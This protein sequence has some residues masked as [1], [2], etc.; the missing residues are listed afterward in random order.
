MEIITW[1]YSSGT[2]WLFSCPIAKYD[3]YIILQIISLDVSPAKRPDTVLMS[4]SYT[5]DKTPD[6]DA[7]VE[8]Y[9][10]EMQAPSNC[11]SLCEGR[12]HRQPACISITEGLKVA[13]QFCDKSSM[14]K[15]EDRPCNTDCRL[16]WVILSK[17]NCFNTVPSISHSIV[18]FRINF[19]VERR[20]QGFFYLYHL[21]STL[22]NHLRA[23]SSCYQ[24]HFFIK[25][26]ED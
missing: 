19:L 20:N 9:R 17:K 15:V 12:S 10:W 22:K 25:K 18:C 14:P 6:L 16:K 7:E 2:I 11:D 24:E 8:I 5:I 26:T 4:Y 21:S 1:S 23:L 13:P 3:L